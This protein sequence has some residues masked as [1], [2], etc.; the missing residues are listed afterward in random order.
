MLAALRADSRCDRATRGCAGPQ[1]VHS[2]P[3]FRRACAADVRTCALE[4]LQGL[5]PDSSSVG[6]HGRGT[7]ATRWEERIKRHCIDG[8]RTP[9]FY[10]LLSKVRIASTCGRVHTEGIHHGSQEDMMRLGDDEKS[11]LVR[12]AGGTFRG[13]SDKEPQS[14]NFKKPGQAQGRARARL[15]LDRSDLPLRLRV[16]TVCRNG[17]SG[18]LRH[19]DQRIWKKETAAEV[20]RRVFSK[21]ID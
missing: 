15:G 11:R 18:H 19:L 7:V 8:Q 4:R 2:H 9:G 1:A 5:R 10:Y 13:Y 20:A 16:L 21:E 12:E 6:Q 17:V 3:V 14:L